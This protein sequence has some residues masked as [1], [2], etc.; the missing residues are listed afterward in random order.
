MGCASSKEASAEQPHGTIKQISGPVCV[1]KETPVLQSFED[2]YRG[3]SAGMEA[4]S[5]ARSSPD[6]SGSQETPSKQHRA[7]A[8]EVARPR[9]LVGVNSP[10]ALKEEIDREDSETSL[11]ERRGRHE[12]LYALPGSRSPLVETPQSHSKGSKSLSANVFPGIEAAKVSRLEAEAFASATARDTTPP[13]SFPQNLAIGKCGTVS[14]SNPLKTSSAN[15]RVAFDNPRSGR[16]RSL[17]LE[18]LPRVN[19]PSPKPQTFVSGWLLD[20][21]LSQ[22]TA[23]FEAAGYDESD[24]L[25]NLSLADL[26]QIETFSRIS[27]LPGHKKRLVLASSR[28]MG[29]TQ[30][31]STNV[32]PLAS[33]GFRGSDLRASDS[34]L[35]DV[36]SEPV[37]F[38]SA[39]SRATESATSSPASVLPTLVL[40][41]QARKSH[42]FERTKSNP[43]PDVP[44][45]EQGVEPSVEG[46]L[47]QALLSQ[48]ES[49]AQTFNPETERAKPLKHALDKSPR[50]R[51]SRSLSMGQATG[52]KR[53]GGGIPREESSV[54]PLEGSVSR[55]GPEEQFPRL[56][57]SPRGSVRERTFGVDSG[58]EGVGRGGLVERDMS[59][60]SEERRAALEELQNQLQAKV[61]QLFPEFCFLQYYLRKTDIQCEAGAA[62]SRDF[63]MGG[64]EYDSSKLC[65]GFQRELLL[66]EPFCHC[67]VTRSFVHAPNLPFL[68][69]G[70]QQSI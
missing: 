30:S 50:E 37:T 10:R 47:G 44:A 58:T 40:P 26:A 68:A 41:E 2:A 66:E 24:S 63:A 27:I 70:V 52:D 57:R 56:K 16:S 18:G 51:R 28:P 32:S 21:N 35:S 46:G 11:Q 54:T 55:R 23:A 7:H 34:K 8:A 38:D 6:A 14:F 39:S 5:L 20:L 15:N 17:A 48:R 67:A 61:G 64:A 49:E 31:A 36:H 22:Y 43:L 45:L 29:L 13:L 53:G 9:N 4:A 62:V 12:H 33:Q 42:A 60:E 65:A 3:Q 69:F 19:A 1:K 25:A 59:A